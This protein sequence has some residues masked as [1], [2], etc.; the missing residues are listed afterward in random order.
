MADAYYSM[1]KYQEVLKKIEKIENDIET[2]QKKLK[3]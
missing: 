1:R 2:Y 3:Q